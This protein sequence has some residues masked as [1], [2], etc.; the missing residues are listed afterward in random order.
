MS[1]FPVLLL[2][3]LQT[4]TPAQQQ[5]AS[6]PPSPIAK[7]VVTPAKP[8]MIARDTLQLSAQALD[9]SGKPVPDVRYRYIGSGEKNAKARFEF[10]VPAAGRYEVRFRYAAH[11]NRSAAVSATVVSGEGEKAVTLNQQQAGPLENGFLSLGTFSFA[12]SA[13]GAVVIA[14]GAAEGNV[15]IDAVQVVPATK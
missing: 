10:T 4:Q 12:P 11:E 8:T 5:T 3:A 15:A 13:A 1:V 2:A 7:L 6:L 9:A 14:P